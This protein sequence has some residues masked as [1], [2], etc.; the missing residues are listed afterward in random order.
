MK[1]EQGLFNQDFTD[2]H[3]VLGISIDAD[4]KQIRKRYLKIARKLHPDSFA[5]A[6]EVERKQASDILSKLVNPA[7]EQLSQ[8]KSASEYSVVLRLK[9]QQMTEQSGSIT[10][11]S[12]AAK[13][14]VGTNN[15]DQTYRNKL[16]D[17]A[18]QQY[19][20]LDQLP[21]ITGQ[22]SELNLAYLIR[23]G[24]LATP[25]AAP[26]PETA[27]STTEATTSDQSSASTAPTHPRQ[28][29]S[30]IIGSY[31]NRAKEFEDRKDYT[32]AILEL[33]EALQSHP[34]SAALHNQL[35]NVYIKSGQPKLAK[36]H[37]SKVLDLS[38]EGGPVAQEAKLKLAALGKS[39]PASNSSKRT[40]DKKAGKSKG[41]LFGLF[42]GK[43]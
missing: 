24:G 42:G 7:Y 37:L 10:W 21:D 27:T 12:K 39:A 6:G 34:K 9:G 14:L 29:R 25:A 19:D 16:N 33:R 4:S 35:A 2:H 22:I 11:T 20:S 40:G 38:A 43:K 18:G 5:S 31:L 3:A 23:K 28:H 30:N 15:V 36:I 8:D 17:L 13:E 32:R 1:I 26:A 41:G